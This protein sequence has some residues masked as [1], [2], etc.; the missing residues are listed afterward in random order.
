[1]TPRKTFFFFSATV[2]FQP[3]PSGMMDD[4]DYDEEEEEDDDDEWKVCESV[5]FGGKQ[6]PKFNSFWQ[7]KNKNRHSTR[8]IC[9][10]A[11]LVVLWWR[12]NMSSLLVSLFVSFVCLAFAVHFLKNYFSFFSPNEGQQFLARVEREKEDG[13]KIK[14]DPAKALATQVPML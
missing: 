5:S 9:C 7:E 3:A 1:M 4:E 14:V 6:M 2:S 10:V 13:P 11:L 8:I 12:W